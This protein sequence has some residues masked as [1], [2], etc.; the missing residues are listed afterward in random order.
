M[1]RPPGHGTPTNNDH[2]PATQPQ[3]DSGHTSAAEPRNHQ[4]LWP[5]PSHQVPETQT[6]R[7]PKTHGTMASARAWPRRSRVHRAKKERPG[8]RVDSLPAPWLPRAHPPRAGRLVINKAQ[9][10]RL[11][12]SRSRWILL[13][14]LGT[15]SL[16]ETTKISKS[17]SSRRQLDDTGRDSINHP[18]NNR[19]QTHPLT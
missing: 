8:A 16:L 12:V 15:G 6:P 7:H 5:C 4:G 13:G 2:A 19:S 3:R 9:T 14:R 10:D 11:L 18:P 17:K 1:L